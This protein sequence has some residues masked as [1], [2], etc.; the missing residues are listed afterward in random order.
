[1]RGA[2]KAG[3][4]FQT[5]VL[6]GDSLKTFAKTVKGLKYRACYDELEN[7]LKQRNPGKVFILYGLR[8]TGKTTMI[9]Q[10]ISSLSKVDFEKTAFIQV[11]PGVTLSDINSDLKWLAS[12]EYQPACKSWHPKN[13]KTR[14]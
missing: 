4:K 10:A 6:I 9:R 14:L 12:K 11:K 7:Y 3:H 1:M 13:I 8:R 5:E 2:I